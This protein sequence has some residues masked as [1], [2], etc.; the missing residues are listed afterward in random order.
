[1]KSFRVLANWKR[2]GEEEGERRGGERRGRGEE[3]ERRGRGEEGRGEGRGRRAEEAKIFA[4]IIF[5]KSHKV[6]N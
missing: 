3:G 2:G 4:E 1:M 5:C 6:F